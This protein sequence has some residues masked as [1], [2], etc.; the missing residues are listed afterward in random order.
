MALPVEP[1]A[2]IERP[3]EHGPDQEQIR[4]DRPANRI[5]LKPSECTVTI[6]LIDYPISDDDALLAYRRIVDANGERIQ[7]SKL[8]LGR[9]ERLLKKHL[10]DEVK[11]TY[12]S[13]T[14]RNGGYWLLPQY[15]R[16]PLIVP[17]RPQ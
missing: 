15:R 17:D 13:E 1:T 3:R 10:P 2:G 5:I 8:G 14:G 11:Q 6:D 4:P 16:R 7:R 9:I 12:A